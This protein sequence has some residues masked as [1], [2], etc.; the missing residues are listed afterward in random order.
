MVTEKIEQKAWN[1][2]TLP[3]KLIKTS[4]SLIFILFIFFIGLTVWYVIISGSISEESQPAARL[5]YNLMDDILANTGAKNLVKKG[6]S[7]VQTPFSEEKQTELLQS[8]TWKSSID[9]SSKKKDLGLEITKFKASND[10]INKESSIEAIAEGSF[11]TTETTQIDFSCLTENNNL[12]EVA[13][14]NNLLTINPNRKEFFT[15]KCIYD[16]E[17]FELDESKTSEAKKIK[18]RATYDFTTEAYI[19]I[20]IL[21]KDVLDYKREEGNRGP[22]REEY[23]IFEDEEIEDSNLNK[24]DRTTFSSYTKGPVKLILRSLYTQPYTGEGPFEAGSY[25]T[26]DMKIDDDTQWTGNVEEIESFE[27]LIP[28]EISIITENFEYSTTEDNFQVYRATDSLLNQLY[29]TCKPKDKIEKITE[30]IRIDEDCWRRGTMIT[31]VEFSINNPSEEI[32]QTFIRSR[33]KY[34][35]NDEKQDTITFIHNQ[36]E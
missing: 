33:L 34:K 4:I 1:I 31:S 29:N 17:L 25:Y 21:Q 5:V 26:L 32:S 28:E 27:I 6:A 11:L 19:P 14:Q 22:V 2:S 9:E 13:N 18:M 15:I 24:N 35:F 7:Y 8:Y 12:G 20:Y 36:D 3:L 10:I 16:R 30:L 23:N